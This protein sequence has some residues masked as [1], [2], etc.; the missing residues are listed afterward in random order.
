LIKT[1]PFCQSSSLCTDAIF[2]CFILL[3]CTSEKFHYSNNNECIYIWLRLDFLFSKPSQHAISYQGFHPPT[4]TH[5]RSILHI[6]TAAGDLWRR[7]GLRGAPSTSPS[8]RTRRSAGRR[9]WEHPSAYPKCCLLL[10]RG[11]STPG[12]ARASSGRRSCSAASTWASAWTR[13]S[14]TPGTP[15]PCS[16]GSGAPGG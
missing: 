1:V 10:R 15:S 14:P 13:G 11:V 9:A 5:G 3:P 16:T 6:G 4:F 2:F 12:Y 8:C 7:A